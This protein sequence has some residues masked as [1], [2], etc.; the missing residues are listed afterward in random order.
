MGFVH[1]QHG[2]WRFLVVDCAAWDLRVS[3][4]AEAQ[5][6]AGSGGALG[7]GLPCG[8]GLVTSQFA[9]VDSGRDQVM[10][11]WGEFSVYVFIGSCRSVPGGAVG[12]CV[13][14]GRVPWGLAPSIYRIC[15]S[16][17]SWEMHQMI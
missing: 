8:A 15:I 1:V 10:L 16:P 14:E 6:V 2:V 4:E 11:R 3:G 13:P 12:H 5:R 9:S 17:G 7:V